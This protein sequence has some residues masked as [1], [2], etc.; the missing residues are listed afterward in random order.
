MIYKN[1]RPFPIEVVNPR[2]GERRA[3][4][5]NGITPELPDG[6]EN[7]YVGYLVP[8]LSSPIPESFRNIMQTNELFETDSRETDGFFKHVDQLM[9]NGGKKEETIQVLNEQKRGRGRPKKV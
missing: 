8:L 1:V 5:P 6:L 2:T 4:Q 7:I 9:E 3:I